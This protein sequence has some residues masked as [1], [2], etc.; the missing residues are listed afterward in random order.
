[1]AQDLCS[2]PHTPF[3]NMAKSSPWNMTGLLAISGQ[4]IQRV[5][6][7]CPHLNQT[8]CRP[9]HVPSA[10]AVLGILTLLTAKPSGSA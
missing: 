3:P 2:L 6:G 1:M 4:P 7:T 9:I 5:G 10:F 8:Q